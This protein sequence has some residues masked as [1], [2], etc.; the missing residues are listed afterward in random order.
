MPFLIIMCLESNK[1]NEPVYDSI[2]SPDDY[3]LQSKTVECN[4]NEKYRN[5]AIDME[6]LMLMLEI[7][8]ERLDVC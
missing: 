8:D 7:V 1:S 3:Y 4:H 6:V 5:V 2:P